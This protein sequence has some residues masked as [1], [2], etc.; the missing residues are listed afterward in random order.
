M[1]HMM[2]LNYCH[3]AKYASCST[4][5][6]TFGVVFYWPLK[7]PNLTALI[8]FAIAWVMDTVLA[9]YYRQIWF[10]T[11]M[12]IANGLEAGGYIARYMSSSNPY[13]Y[14]NYVAQS[15]LLIFALAFFMAGIYY[16]LGE[17]SVIWGIRY[18][19]FKPW[20]YTKIFVTLDV[21]SI[22][23]QGVSHS[24]FLLRDNQVLTIPQAGTDIMIGGLGFQVAATLLFMLLCLAYYLRIRN[25]R[26]LAGQSLS[27]FAPSWELNIESAQQGA[28]PGDAPAKFLPIR[29]AKKTKVFLFAVAAAVLLVFVRSVYR[30]VELSTGW[31]GYLMTEEGYFFVLDAMMVALASWIMWIFHPGVYLGRINI[32]AEQRAALFTE[33][34]NVESETAEK[35][36]VHY[37]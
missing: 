7:A 20:A 10:G 31:S 34:S 19:R 14:G 37:I 36:A 15:V 13:T 8:L 2:R 23:I 30:V 32:G 16:L 24:S 5:L 17:V 28:I 21:L 11:C 35:E 1:P 27:S 6:T 25:H 22:I 33:E 9:I 3:D 12:F 26:R 18:A 4:N 29:E